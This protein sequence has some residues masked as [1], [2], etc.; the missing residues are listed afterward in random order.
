[1]LAIVALIKERRLRFGL[2]DIL[3]RLVEHWRSN[4][5]KQSVYPNRG[6]DD[7]DDDRVWRK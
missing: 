6:V 2:Q 7:G 3:K 1:L 5:N 4:A